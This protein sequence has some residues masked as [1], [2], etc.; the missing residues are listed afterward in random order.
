MR[1]TARKHCRKKT[2]KRLRKNELRSDVSVRR[3]EKIRF[4]RVLRADV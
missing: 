3:E 2:R 1:E 4:L